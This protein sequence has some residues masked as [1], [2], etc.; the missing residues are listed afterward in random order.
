MK[1]GAEYDARRQVGLK[2]RPNLVGP[3]GPG[4]TLRALRRVDA[5]ELE[6]IAWLLPGARGQLC[7]LLLAQLASRGLLK[8]FRESKL[9]GDGNYYRPA[10][11]SWW[12]GLAGNRV[13]WPRSQSVVV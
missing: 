2:V 3:G 11:G 4:Q 9:Q 12:Q 10:G 5:L 6:A 7:F 13:P 8:A 1:H